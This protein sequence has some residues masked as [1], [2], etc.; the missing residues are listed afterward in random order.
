MLTHVESGGNLEELKRFLLDHH[1]T[2]QLPETATVFLADLE[3]KLGACRAARPAVLLEWADPA[4]SH[5]LA[6]S[7][8]TNKLCHHA[9][10]NRLVVAKDDLAAFRRAAKKLGYVVPAP[11]SSPPDSGPSRRP[12]SSG[13][14]R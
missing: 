5:L 1:A 9:G 2:G 8:G 7:P 6:T 13:A 10:E 3:Q 12:T 4:L 11:P 14:R